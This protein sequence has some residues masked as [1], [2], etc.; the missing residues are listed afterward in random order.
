[1]DNRFGI[2]VLSS[3]SDFL[4][5]F[6]NLSYFYLGV[7][8]VKT[9]SSFFSSLSGPMASAYF[10]SSAIC[11]TFLSDYV[12]TSFFSVSYFSFF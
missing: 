2:E 5:T 11:A 10:K 4:R 9:L 1:M 12:K 7:I 3:I 8:I 6:D